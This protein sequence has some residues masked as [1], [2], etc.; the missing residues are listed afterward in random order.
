M[1]NTPSPWR[2]SGRGPNRKVPQKPREG[3]TQGNGRFSDRSRNFP[4]DLSRVPLWLSL[5]VYTTAR[6]SFHCSPKLINE[7]PRQNTRPE[8]P[9]PESGC[10]PPARD[11]YLRRAFHP[12]T[13]TFHGTASAALWPLCTAVI[14]GFFDFVEKPREECVDAAVAIAFSE[15]ITQT[16]SRRW[17]YRG[18]NR[19]GGGTIRKG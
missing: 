15:Q 2:R 3:R 6:H 4:E 11:V 10:T 19:V 13:R 5:H 8:R 16:N 12:S 14:R 1:R 17:R 7:P 18:N 9:T